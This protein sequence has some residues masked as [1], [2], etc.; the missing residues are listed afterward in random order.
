MTDPSAAPAALERGTV[1]IDVDDLPDLDELAERYDNH[2]VFSRLMTG[3]EP[4]HPGTLD[5]P[6]GRRRAR[7]AATS[8]R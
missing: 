2:V 7:S 6:V 5:L 3:D 8:S 4:G 1:R